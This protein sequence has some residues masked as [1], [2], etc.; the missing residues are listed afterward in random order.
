MPVLA[1]CWTTVWW[2]ATVPP[3]DMQRAQ[4]CLVAF[5]S[6]RHT[7]IYCVTRCT[8]CYLEFHFFMMTCI[9]TQGAARA[10]SSVKR[11]LGQL[12]RGKTKPFKTVVLLFVTSICRII[13]YPH[14]WCVCTIFK[15]SASRHRYAKWCAINTH[16]QHALLLASQPRLSCLIPSLLLSGFSADIKMLMLL[17]QPGIY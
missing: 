15:A 14:P 13:N 10:L 4:L 8:V 9:C 6:V 17:R 2:R 12:L 5:H 7:H 11:C 3:E 16:T 1:I